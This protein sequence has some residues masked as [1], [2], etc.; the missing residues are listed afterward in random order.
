MV[1]FSK[2]PAVKKPTIFGAARK[3]FDS[4]YIVMALVSRT[5]SEASSVSVVSN[6]DYWEDFIDWKLIEKKLCTIEK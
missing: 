4:S 3:M 2:L 6:Y 5:S 1:S